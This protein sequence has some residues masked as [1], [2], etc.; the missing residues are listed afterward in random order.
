M[1]WNEWQ[2]PIRLRTKLVNSITAVITCIDP[3]DIAHT[4]KKEKR[5]K[6]HFTVAL[7]VIST[8]WEE[9]IEIKQLNWPWLYGAIIET[10]DSP[11]PVLN[12]II[13]W[14]QVRKKQRTSMINENQLN[15]F[16]SSLDD[17]SNDILRNNDAFEFNQKKKMK[18]IHKY[19]EKRSQ[20]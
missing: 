1:H 15:Y 12:S 11:K 18:K 8:L 3:N 19:R 5:K 10:I 17:I 14:F 13:F 20:E 16:L 9:E 4:K 6:N 2:T 7:A